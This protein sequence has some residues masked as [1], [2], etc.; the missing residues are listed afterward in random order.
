MRVSVDLSSLGETRWYEYAARFV[1]GGSITA[2]AGLIAD[3]WGPV[4]G[5]LFLAFPAIFPAGATLIAK[6]ERERKAEAGLNGIVRGSLAAAADAAGAAM[7]SLGLIAFA[8]I[9]WKLLPDHRSSLV[10]AVATI[11]WISV[12]SFTWMARKQR[13]WRRNHARR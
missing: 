4:V 7:G 3:R 6:H 10:L 9:V 13:W 2:I 12:S 5:G 1:L 8:I 11:G